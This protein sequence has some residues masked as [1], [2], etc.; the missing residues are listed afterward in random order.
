MWRKSIADR[1]HTQSQ[2]GMK[3]FYV[4]RRKNE[5]G[6]KIGKTPKN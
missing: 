4:L 2:G 6:V 5:G 3:D 1:W